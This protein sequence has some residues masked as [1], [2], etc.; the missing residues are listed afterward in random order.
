MSTPQTADGEWHRVHP[1]S[2]LVRGWFV[3][4]GLL[5]FFIQS[6]G[7]DLVN[8][9][10]D[11]GEFQAARGLG[12]TLAI[13]AG[14]FIIALIGF[15]LS[16]RF[17][18]YRLTEETVQIR[19]GVLFRQRREVRLDRVQAVDLRQP[20]L[21]R[22]VGLAELKFEAAD[23]G[24]GAA[25]ALEYIRR[26]EAESLRREIM[27]RAAGIQAG[28]DPA[29]AADPQARAEQGIVTSADAG[30]LATDH[31]VPDGEGARPLGGD[32]ADV[33]R[34]MPEAPEQIMLQVPVKRLV[35]SVA[36]GAV[37]TALVTLVVLGAIAWLV[38][39]FFTDLELTWDNVL[40][41]LMIGLIPA[42]ISAVAALWSQFNAG[43]NFTVATS[44]DGLRLRYGLLETNQ[45]TVPPG[46]VQAVK[47]TQPLFW[48]PFGWHKVVVNVAGYGGL[49]EISEGKKSLVLPVGTFEDV[50]RVLSVVAPDPGMTDT[51]DAPE[52]IRAGISGSGDTHGYRHSPRRARW[53]DL[54]TWRRNALRSTQTMILL[55]RGR[56][57]RSLVLMPH[58]R[59]Q[60]VS[61]EQGPIDRRLRL[62]SLLFHSTAGPVVPLL[63][64]ADVDVAVEIFEQESAIA[65]VSRRMSDRNQW[66]RPE[67]KAR[68]DRR[69][70]EAIP[71]L[72]EETA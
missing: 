29:E 19:S 46:R 40:R 35:G 10:L 57:N 3:V 50:L 39:A 64:H 68:F 62:A 47:V 41:P 59:L 43:Y 17:T 69:T 45:Q 4:A 15:F 16:W 13:F 25:L 56:L 24:T 1:I 27:G 49:A 33:G 11:G 42:A 60:S 20:L 7:E 12:I 52:V 63:Y 23:G 6:A 26:E 54:L 66:M 31:Q 38:I 22:I 2:P 30:T 53:V 32:G 5:F 65:A 34:T 58:D 36:L 70:A 37:S 61:L 44:P 71:V 51:E 55:R 72:A 48:R 67:E 18:R 28:Q 9:L 8:V 21:A 14:V